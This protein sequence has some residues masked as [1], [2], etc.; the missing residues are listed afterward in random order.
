MSKPTIKVANLKEVFENQGITDWQIWQKPAS[1]TTPSH[2][3]GE[4]N[5]CGPC[6]DDGEAALNN[7]LSHEDMLKWRT[8]FQSLANRLA[9]GNCPKFMHGIKKRDTNNAK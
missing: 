2:M 7:K 6:R 8:K 3:S 4:P 5:C 9:G 1:W